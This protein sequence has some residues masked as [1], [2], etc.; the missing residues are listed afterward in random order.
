MIFKHNFVRIIL[1]TQNK[2]TF[3]RLSMSKLTNESHPLP[4]KANESF[5]HKYPTTA[6]LAMV[7]ARY[8]TDT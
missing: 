1:S 7:T 8:D 6:W 2:A 5:L 4:Y 3:A